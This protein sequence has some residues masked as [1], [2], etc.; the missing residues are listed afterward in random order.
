[1]ARSSLLS[2]TKYKNSQK[3]IVLHSRRVFAIFDILKLFF[4]HKLVILLRITSLA[5]VFYWN[6][7]ISEL[8]ELIKPSLQTKHLFCSKLKL[9]L[10]KF[11][12]KRFKRKIQ[13]IRFRK[14]A[15]LTSANYTHAER[16]YWLCSVTKTVCWVYL[17]FCHHNIFNH[18]YQ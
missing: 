17:Y 12:G 10:W 7:N 8:M 14:T 1:M 16:R 13:C 18:C 2:N 4:L 11:D 3:K 6:S 5:V 15:L 9:A